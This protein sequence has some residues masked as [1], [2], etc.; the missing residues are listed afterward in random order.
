[1]Q[2][3]PGVFASKYVKPNDPIKLLNSHR[4]EWKVFCIEHNARSST[5]KA[6]SPAMQITQGFCQFIRENNLAYGDCCVY[7][8]IEENPPVLVVTMFRVVDYRD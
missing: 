6:K 4:E 7:E 5:H 1:V 2:Y 8:L 3:V